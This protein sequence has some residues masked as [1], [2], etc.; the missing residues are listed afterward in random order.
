MIAL[1]QITDERPIVEDII[2][3]RL[4]PIDLD[5]MQKGVNDVF[6]GE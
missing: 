2:S 5:A 1:Y 3:S 6:V 4:S